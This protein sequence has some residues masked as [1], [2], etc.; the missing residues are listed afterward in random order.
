MGH[1]DR[2]V[3]HTRKAGGPSR[4]NAAV[5]RTLEEELAGWGA[6]LV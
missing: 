5:V 2:V 1:F 4:A 6:G 3:V